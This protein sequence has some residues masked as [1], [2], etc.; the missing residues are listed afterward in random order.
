MTTLPTLR[1]AAKSRITLAIFG[2][3]TLG[4]LVPQVVDIYASPVYL[5]AF[6]P[7]YP[8]TMLLYD[9]PVGLE[10]LV[11]PIS[12]FVEPVLSDGHLVWE[13][14]RYVTFYLFALLVGWVVALRSRNPP[15]SDSP[16]DFGTP[17]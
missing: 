15:W 5:L 3:L 4:A 13:A 16:A 14:G 6:L 8:V 1:A 17:R 2:Y 9:S 12:A 7:S 10:N 11:Y